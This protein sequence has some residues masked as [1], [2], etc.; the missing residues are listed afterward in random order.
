MNAITENTIAAKTVTDV[1]EFYRGRFGEITSKIPAEISSLIERVL[2]EISFEEGVTSRNRRGGFDAFNCD[3]YGY[4][5]KRKLAAIQLRYSWK[6]RESDWLNTSKWYAL[7]GIDEGQIFSHVIDTSFRRNPDIDD[8][9]PEEIVRWAESKIFR[10]PVAR[11]DTII[12][13]GDVALVPVR[14]IPRSA[15]KIDGKDYRYTF[16]K[17]HKVRVDGWA[18]IDEE[19]HRHWLDGIVEI[20]HIPG[21]H[22]PI[23]G[24]GR[25]EVVCGKRLDVDFSTVD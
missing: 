15:K 6:R 13:Q 22:K 12:R 2:K 21:Q 18:Y 4:D 17:S 20:D 9:T 25:F 24:E 14:S 23:G 10:V 5:V 19:S 7:V 8:A 3:V 1:D 16:R 11:L